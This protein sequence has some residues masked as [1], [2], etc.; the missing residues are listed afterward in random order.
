MVFSWKKRVATFCV[1]GAV[2]ATVHSVHAQTPSPL[3]VST[4]DLTKAGFES[5]RTQTQT[6]DG[7]YPKTNFYFWV[8]ANAKQNPTNNLVM[9]STVSVAEPITNLFKYSATPQDFPIEGGIGK[10]ATLIGT[11]T[12]INFYKKGTYVVVIGPTTRETRSLAFAI[13]DMIK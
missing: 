2:F 9:V 8:G 10:E 3:S 5:P 6:T 1:L 7:S 13:A 12:A 11:R 4:N